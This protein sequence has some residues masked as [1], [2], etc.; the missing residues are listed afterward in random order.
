M[1]K[2]NYCRQ[3]IKKQISY[4][5]VKVKEMGCEATMI[6]FWMYWRNS[7]S[8][9]WTQIITCEIHAYNLLNTEASW[10]KGARVQ[11]FIVFVF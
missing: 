6:D 1:V 3:W 11:Y 2:R 10:G 9:S 4:I 5:L 7:V 8:S